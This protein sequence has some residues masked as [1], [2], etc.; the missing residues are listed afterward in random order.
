MTAQ[1]ARH[2][3]HTCNDE[4]EAGMTADLARGIQAAHAIVAA[5][6]TA[7]RR[8]PAPGSRDFEAAIAR[9]KAA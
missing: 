5:D 3:L 1:Q 4:I 7:R 2:F 6:Q 9:L 8:L